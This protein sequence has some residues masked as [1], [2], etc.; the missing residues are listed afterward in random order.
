MV[1][2]RRDVLASQGIRMYRDP[3]DHDLLAF[4][5][6]LLIHLNS[7][8]PL[9]CAAF[10]SSINHL[11]KDCILPI[12]MARLLECNEELAAIGSW[13]LVRHRHHASGIMSESRYL[14]L[15]LEVLS[16]YRSAA[17]HNRA[18]RRIS[19]GLRRVSSLDHEARNQPVER[20]LVIRAGCAQSEKVLGGL[21]DRFAKYFEL[22]VPV[23]RV[24]L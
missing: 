4:R 8:H 7:L 19:R 23:G 24:K 18:L 13:A 10:F 15:V 16:P 9:Q 21:G 3:F 11:A 5:S 20:R 22:D 12:Q 14:N 1:V 17:F 6:A 2:I